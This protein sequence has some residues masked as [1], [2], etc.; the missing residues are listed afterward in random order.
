M[1]GDEWFQRMLP[2]PIY[3]SEATEQNFPTD[4]Q[5]RLQLQPK[6]E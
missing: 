1:R 2:I 3:T 6:Y 4:A 5:V